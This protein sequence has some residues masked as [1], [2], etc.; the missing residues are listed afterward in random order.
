MEWLIN[1]L[2]N[3][4]IKCIRCSNNF[5]SITPNNSIN[6]INRFKNINRINSIKTCEK[7]I[8]LIEPIADLILSV[9]CGTHNSFNR[10]V[11][12]YKKPV[13]LYYLVMAFKTILFI[14][15]HALIL[16]F[17]INKWC[18][19]KCNCIFQ[20][21]VYFLIWCVCEGDPEPVCASTDLVTLATIEI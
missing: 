10:K 9:T 7:C 11:Y 4:L 15:I 19:S 18:K 6:R 8:L 1:W 12:N 5:N 14:W 21:N 20:L 16:P 13:H 2:I 17:W 3:W